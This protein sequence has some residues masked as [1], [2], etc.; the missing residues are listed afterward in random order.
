MWE[1]VPSLYQMRGIK[2]WMN[3]PSIIKVLINTKLKV[4][5]GF[6]GD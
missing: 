6:V 5:G 4:G 2:P 3:Y 1:D